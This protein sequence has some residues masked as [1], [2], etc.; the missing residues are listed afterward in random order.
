MSELSR[1]VR[2]MAPAMLSLPI[3]L[4]EAAMAAGKRY[5]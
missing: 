4:A 5:R 2:V 3:E 1:I